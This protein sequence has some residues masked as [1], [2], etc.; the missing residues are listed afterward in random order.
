M[1]KIYIF[2][3]LCVS[4]CFEIQ[5]QYVSTDT[6]L[7]VAENFFASRLSSKSKMSMQIHSFGSRKQPTMYAF[8]LAD[9]WVLIAGDR[10][11]PPI[12][13][14]S[15]ENGGEFPSV[16]DM[17][18]G[19]LYMLDWYNEQVENLRDENIDRAYNSQWEVYL[20]TNHQEISSHS[21][22]VGPLLIYDGNENIWKQSGNNNGNDISKSYNKFCPPVHTTLESCEHAIVGCVAVATSQVM[23][24]WQWPHAA[25]VNDDFGNKI[26][27]HYDWSLMPFQLTNSSELSQADMIANL[28]HDVGVA[29]NMSYGCNGSS[30]QPD[31]IPPALRNKFGYNASNLLKRNNY[32]ENIWLHL[33]KDE[34]NALRPVLYGGQSATEGHRF[35]IDGYD[36]DNKFHINYGWGSWGNGFYSLN[37]ISYNTNQSMVINIHPNYPSCTLLVIPSTEVWNTNFLVQNGGAI[38]V[39]NRTVTSGMQGAILSGESVTLTSGFQIEAG[40]EVYIGIKDMHC[41]DDRG[42]IFIDEDA[43]NFHYAP[44]KEGSITAPSAT[45]IL[46]DGQ[47]LILRDGRIYTPTG[48]EVK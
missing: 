29:V 7:Q 37:N 33:I 1:K 26:V 14:Y 21:I 18:N 43:P 17:P 8:S 12:L 36:S 23:W 16:E 27:R 22:V 31:N 38:S 10:R 45:K 44:Q 25:I 13:A 3:G 41:D 32:V 9:N 40:A 15:D 2:L 47:I 30:A 35:V 46:R 28:L 20:D 39:G 48:Q 5:A 11:M 19:M 42:E 6:A 4:F 34:L 24:Y